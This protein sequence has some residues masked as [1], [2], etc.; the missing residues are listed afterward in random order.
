ME[1]MESAFIVKR[2][3]TNESFVLTVILGE[4]VSDTDNCYYILHKRK[5]QRVK[6]DS[7]VGYWD[8]VSG[9]SLYEVIEKCYDS[10]K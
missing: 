10:V 4:I 2:K 5:L 6:K 1:I 3:V 9:D 7:I 8:E